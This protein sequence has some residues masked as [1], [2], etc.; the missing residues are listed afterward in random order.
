MVLTA[1][2]MGDDSSATYSEI[3]NTGKITEFFKSNDVN[4]GRL[5][6]YV[7][8]LLGMKPAQHEYKVM[9]L[10][11]YG[12]QYHGQ[13][14]LDFFKKINK[15]SG[16]E[17]IN[18]KLVKDLYFT[19]KDSLEGE[20]FDGIAWGLQTYL[21]E[22]LCE[23]VSNI[24]KKHNNGNVIFSGGVAQNIKACK[25]IID[26]PE[27][28]KFWTGPIS[29]DGSLA[30]GAVWLAHLKSSSKF[31]I[32]GLD[33]IYLGTSFTNIQIEEHIKKNKTSQKFKII[34]NISQ[35][36]IAD[37]LIDGKIISRFAGKMELGQRALGNRSII[38]DPRNYEVLE[39]INKKI[40]YRDFWMPFTPSILHEDIN[41]Y[42]INKKNIYSPLI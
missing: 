41:D 24:C 17:I 32:S 20:R 13:N 37:W 21:E 28:E 26:L 34:D 40:K 14:S 30:I 6:R 4:L 39:R 16:T 35:T 22:I 2:G 10:A 11:P 31:P 12:S 19:V 5:Y 1:E 25:S 29:G 18:E 3:T 38:A 9:G 15:V 7:T 23:W 36:Q 33:T 27:V 8:L 42:V